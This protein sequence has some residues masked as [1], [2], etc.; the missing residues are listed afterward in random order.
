MTEVL[1]FFLKYCLPFIVAYLLNFL[2]NKFLSKEMLRGKIH[3]IFLKGIIIAVIWAAA[4]L[5]AL[6]GIP[7]FSKT[8]ETAV[9]SSGI[10]AVVL[11]LAAQSTLANVFAGIALSAS[12]SRPFDIGDRIMINSYDPGFVENITLRHTVIKTYQNEII[13]I[14]NS[15]VGAATIVNYTQE[16]SFSYPIDISVAYGTDMERAK[17]IMADVITAHPKHC[18]SRPSVLCRSCDDSGVTLRALMETADFKDNPIACSDVRIELMKRFSE[19]GI[20]IP[21]NKLVLINGKE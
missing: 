13:Y 19:E 16:K 9:A 21:Y 2:M 1:N 8:W 15:I 4:A 14:P 7:A 17:E 20:E 6:S 18:G 5:T 12:H 10:A 3:L 11:G